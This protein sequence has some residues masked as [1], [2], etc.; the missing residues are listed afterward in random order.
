MDVVIATPNVMAQMGKIGRILGPRGLMPNPKSGTV[1]PNVGD[2]VQEVKAGKIAFRV[3]K[4][5]I[6]HNSI[7]RVSFTPEQLAQNAEELLQLIVKMKPSSAKGTY[8]KSVSVASTIFFWV[9]FIPAFVGTPM[10]YATFVG[11]HVLRNNLIP[12][13][14]R[15][16]ILVLHFARNE[17]NSEI[18]PRILSVVLTTAAIRKNFVAPEQACTARWL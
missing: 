17:R 11:Y 4:Y 13:P 2:A 10:I 1:T 18:C 3:D 12:P 14:G 8:M 16:R 6:I 15:R 9:V 7:G 5:G